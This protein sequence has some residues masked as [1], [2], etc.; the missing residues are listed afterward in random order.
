MR[1]LVLALPLVLVG[2]ASSPDI[3]PLRVGATWTYRVHA[4]FPI[5]AEAVKVV[6]RTAVSGHEGFVL[7]GPLGE[8]T[9]SWQGK[10]LVAE[11][12]G[13]VRFDPPI[14]LLVLNGSGAVWQ[15]KMS[16]LTGVESAAANLGQA[17]ETITLNGKSYKTT[18]TTLT[19]SSQAHAIELTT[20]FAPGSGIVRQ[21]QLTD[22]RQNLSLELVS[23]PT[24]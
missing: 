20:W 13:A 16:G 3:M 19:L 18:R 22:G 24:E 7:E 9:M 6:R 10:R 11:R 17:S 5:Y 8:S 15:G 21:E 4:D 23:G 1:G 2:C 14:P 12:L